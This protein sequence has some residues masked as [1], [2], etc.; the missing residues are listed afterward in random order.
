M[1]EIEPPGKIQTVEVEVEVLSAAAVGGEG[2]GAEGEGLHGAEGAGKMKKIE[3]ER[4]GASQAVVSG[5]FAYGLISEVSTG[6]MFYI[7]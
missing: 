1:A 7:Q 3:E 6:K 2:G 5:L 4:K